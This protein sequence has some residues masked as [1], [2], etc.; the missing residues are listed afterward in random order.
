MVGLRIVQASVFMLVLVNTLFAQPSE[1]GKGSL[2]GTVV[3]KTTSKPVEFATISIFKLADS[4]LVTGSISSATGTFLVDKIPNGTFYVKIEFIGFEPTIINNVEFSDIKNEVN[5][6]AINLAS[7][8]K[9][10][11]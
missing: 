6:G 5:L 9:N 11:D 10:M 4:T 7:F 3:D 2:L 1:I 8:S